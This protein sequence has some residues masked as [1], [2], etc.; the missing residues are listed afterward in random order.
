MVFTLPRECLAAFFSKK[1]LRQGGSGSHPHQKGRRPRPLTSFRHRGRRD[2]ALKQLGPHGIGNRPVHRGN[3]LWR[4][5]DLLPRSIRPNQMKHAAIRA[6]LRDVQ[7]HLRP[8]ICI[9]PKHSPGI[10]C[11]Q[12]CQPSG[13][14]GCPLC[15]LHL[16]G[17][18]AL[19]RVFHHRRLCCASCSGT[20]D[21]TYR[22]ILGRALRATVQNLGPEHCL[23]EMQHRHLSTKPTR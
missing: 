11:A 3:T 7:R 12:S 6:G 20:D 22:R 21:Q 19:K 23:G 15:G 13:A 2:N 1:G 5:L 10:G 16:G 18:F 4:P 9:I 8:R 14:E 17:S